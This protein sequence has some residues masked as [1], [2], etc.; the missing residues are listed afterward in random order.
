VIVLIITSGALVST[1]CAD[2]VP[3]NA[4]NIAKMGRSKSFFITD[5]AKEDFGL[6]APLESSSGGAASKA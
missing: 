1:A 5:P 4:M 3:Q 6:S 2:A